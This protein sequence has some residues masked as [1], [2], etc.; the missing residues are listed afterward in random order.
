[1]AYSDQEIADLARQLGE[2]GAAP[3][4]IESFVASAKAQQGRTSATAAPVSPPVTSTQSTTL[5][6]G[7]AIN[8]SMG[9]LGRAI[10]DAGLE[11]GGAM[12]GQALGA[13]GG[14]LDPVTVP[15]GGGVGGMVGNALAQQR[16]MS[17]G[18]QN[19]FRWGQMFGAFPV[20]AVP[21]GPLAKAGVG[22]LT[23]EAGKYALA[24]LAGKMT[25][26][27]VDEGRLPTAG[28]TAGA[29]VLGAAGPVLAAG[30]DAGAGAAKIL[31]KTMQNS[32]RDA[33]L[34]AARAAG[35]VIPASRVNPGP[36]NNLLESV[37]GKASTLQEAAVRNQEITNA[38]ARKAVGLP[39][40]APITTQTLAAVREKAAA[41]YREIENLANQAKSDL[42][43]LKKSK[44]TASNPHEL[45]IQM[46]DPATV[47]EA[48]SLAIKA[49]ADVD[50]LKK[51]R[52][53][54][55]S[56]YQFYHRSGDPKALETAR[57]AEKRAAELEDSLQ[58]AAKEMG[59]PELA[60]ELFASRVRIAKT[61]EIEKA[62]NIADS[63]VSAPIL[64]RSI[65]K[66][67]PLTGG[68]KTA[69]KFN[70]AFPQV[71]R[72][73]ATVPSPGVSKMRMFSA[74]ALGGGG[75]AGMGPKGAMLGAIPFMEGPARTLAL[76]K[77]WQAFMAKP[78]YGV[79]QADTGARFLRQ[80]TANVGRNDFLKFLSE[81]YPAQTPAQ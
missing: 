48:S 30:A 46:S 36:I 55:T 15:L 43:A 44:F 19:G 6:A 54:A 8:G 32:A 67:A 25:Q 17:M 62:L 69:A 72:E 68:L 18:E 78:A 13:M 20:G 58:A 63:N 59:K 65:D 77:P 42:D 80:T 71:T 4:E 60:A 14:P 74:L 47:K 33:T 40:N 35:Y 38:L 23:K 70:Q 45:E 37:A 41:P 49:G 22:T 2:K 79:P 64:G 73:G 12:A 75:A 24:N 52:F 3:G 61:Y 76:S 21:G 51:A 5:P 53:D 26:T 50:A 9:P 31:A 1:M 11:G 27:A 57:A 28:E 7:R 39:I 34:A 81:A 66:D 56:N 16:R 29:V 10:A